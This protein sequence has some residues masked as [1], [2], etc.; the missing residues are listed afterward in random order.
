MRRQ[1]VRHHLSSFFFP[2]CGRCARGLYRGY[3]SPSVFFAMLSLC[4]AENTQ[5]VC[6]GVIVT[7]AAT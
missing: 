4:K 7:R 1:K 2:A 6:Q 5:N 3:H